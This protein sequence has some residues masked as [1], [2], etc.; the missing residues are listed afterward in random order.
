MLDRGGA[1][2]SANRTVALRIRPDD[3]LIL[4][5]KAPGGPRVDDER[6]FSQ[7]LTEV[8]ITRVRRSLYRSAAKVWEDK[9]YP[10]RIDLEALQT[11]D[12]APGW[13][14]GRAAMRALRL[15][16][17]KQGAP[18]AGDPLAIAAFD[19]GAHSDQD[20]ELELAGDLDALVTA[21]RRR[22]QRRLRM[23]KFGSLTE[24]RC[25]LCGRT[26][27]VRLVSAAHIKRRADATRRE[28]LNPD[29]I[30]AACLL[31]CDALFEHGHVHVDPT[32]TIRVGRHVR[33]ELLAAARHLA[34]RQCPAYTWRS[35]TFFEA[36]AT[37]F[38]RPGVDS[39]WPQANWELA[40]DE[41]AAGRPLRADG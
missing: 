39:A 25:D 19:E 18:V 34:G 8:L 16:G 27:P 11:L 3:Y 21:V 38:S 24:A 6:F 26:L 1:D 32:G 20:D 4:G 2:G 15:S 37:R 41:Q 13:R 40:A 30:M 35:R 14:L 29:N 33:G 9:P 36:H 28:R 12:Q 7:E 31:G 5:F 10:E 23:L 17:T 22:E